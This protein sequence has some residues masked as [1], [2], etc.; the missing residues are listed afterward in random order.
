MYVCTHVCIC[1]RD[2]QEAR[3]GNQIP[4]QSGGELPNVGA[5]NLSLLFCIRPTSALNSLS[6]LSS[7]LLCFKVLYLFVFHLYFLQAH[8]V[9][10]LYT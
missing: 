4:S 9:H 3:I 5:E 7:S 6:H 8:L 2:T 10:V 1:A